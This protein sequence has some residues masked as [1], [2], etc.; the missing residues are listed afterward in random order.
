MNFPLI[1]YIALAVFGLCGLA[2][3]ERARIAKWF[4]G[5]SKQKVLA[6]LDA[7]EKLA[8]SLWQNHIEPTFK[9]IEA[10]VE[11]ATAHAK[12]AVTTANDVKAAVVDAIAQPN[13]AAP[14]TSPAT[15][16]VAE[17]NAGPLPQPATGSGGTAPVEPAADAVATAHA[18]L[19]ATIQHHQTEADAHLARVSEAKDAKAQLTA[20]AVTAAA[21]AKAVAD[22]APQA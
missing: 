6:D 18:A 4:G 5:N 14:A 21:Q 13:P 22:P 8:E 9:T 3:M 15:A 19:D 17:S 7:T 20:S 12:S 1:A 11:A 2:W 10:K 16:P